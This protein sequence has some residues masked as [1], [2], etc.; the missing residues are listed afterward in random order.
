MVRLSTTER[1]TGDAP[2]IG[3]AV[4]GIYLTSGVSSIYCNRS[5]AGWS[6]LFNDADLEARGEVQVIRLDDWSREHELNRIDFIKIDIEGSEYRALVGAKETLHRFKPTIVVEIN[7][8]CLARDGHTA[9]DVLGLLAAEG[10]KC[11]PFGDGALA[12]PR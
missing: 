2:D 5:E 11:I 6:S 9:S 4:V 10:Y 1:F 7:I 12:V 3:V 8:P